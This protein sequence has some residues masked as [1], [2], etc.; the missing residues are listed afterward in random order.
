[1]D[2]LIRHIFMRYGH[3]RHLASLSLAF[4]PFF[5]S[6]WF[7]I[8]C[9][10]CLPSFI[11]F[12][13]DDLHKLSRRPSDPYRSTSVYFWGCLSLSAAWCRWSCSECRVLA[14]HLLIEFVSLS[15]NEELGRYRE[16][17]KVF[18]AE[19]RCTSAPLKNNHSPSTLLNESIGE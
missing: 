1:M 4:Q 6:R 16:I 15:T 9:D 2:Y 17:E 7:C 13:S 14:C 10:R 18:R 11:S 12:G 3:S 19:D 5:L 8:T